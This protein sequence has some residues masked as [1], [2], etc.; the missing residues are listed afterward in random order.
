MQQIERPPEEEGEP[1]HAVL[2]RGREAAEDERGG[3]R[4]EEDG[5]R[6]FPE[7]FKEK[8][9]MRQEEGNRFDDV[10]A[11]V[12]IKGREGESVIALGEEQRGVIETRPLGPAARERREGK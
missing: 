7:T 12:L 1:Q 11:E 8:R 9:G 5:E 6:G 2:F 3:Q 10:T 4:G